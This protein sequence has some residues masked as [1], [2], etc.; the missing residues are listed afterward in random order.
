MKN[1]RLRRSLSLRRST[2]APKYASAP[3]ASEA[4]H[5][6]IFDQPDARND[7]KEKETIS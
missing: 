1:A 3:Q 4:L 6:G 2:Y 7:K 5:P